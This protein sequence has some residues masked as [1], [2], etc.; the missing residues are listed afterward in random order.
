LKE[1]WTGVLLGLACVPVLYGLSRL[2]S[3]WAVAALAAASAG[4]FL[5]GHIHR[6]RHQADHD[7][8]TG[9]KNRRPFERALAA[10]CRQQPASLLFIELDDFGLINKRYGHLLGDQALL[11]VSRLLEQN[12]RRTDLLARWGGDEFVLLLPGT[13]ADS[14]LRLAERIRA[15]IAATPFRQGEVTIPLSVSTGVAALTAAGGSPEELLRRAEQAHRI[16]KQRKNAV[17]L[18]S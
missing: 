7:E 2:P 17:C 1:R 3:G 13:D 12:T 15:T 10:V 11:S 16:A 8:L 18:C 5:G 4:W 9:V 14:A 6:M